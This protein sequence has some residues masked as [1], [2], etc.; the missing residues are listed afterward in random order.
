MGNFHSILLG[1]GA[2][3]GFGPYGFDGDEKNRLRGV[4][5]HDFV[6]DDVEGYVKNFSTYFKR[7]G[8]D[9]GMCLA[10]DP[11][12]C[13]G[14]RCLLPVGAERRRCGS[15]NRASIGGQFQAS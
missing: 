9:Y 11:A 6:E 7:A 3:S 15:S 10:P 1:Y 5:V 8:D 4:R 13:R 12:D 2:S 14:G